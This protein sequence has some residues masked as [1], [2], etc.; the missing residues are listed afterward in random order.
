M[1]VGSSIRAKVKVDAAS[2]KA[3]VTGRYFVSAI[4]L[5]DP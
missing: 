2:G 3:F 5:E 1:K 4:D